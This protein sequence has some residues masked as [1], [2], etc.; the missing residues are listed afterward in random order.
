MEN[1]ESE[2]EIATEAEMELE[3]NWY[4]TR[5]GVIKIEDV[6]MVLLTINKCSSMKF[7]KLDSWDQIQ[8]VIYIN[9][10]L[11]FAPFP[12]KGNAVCM[13]PFHDHMKRYE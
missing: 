5:T 3:Q 12:L 8:S 7:E 11:P 1:R 2:M 10:P 6:L 9:T 13:E 4:R